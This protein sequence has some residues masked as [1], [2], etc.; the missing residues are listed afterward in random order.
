MQGGDKLFFSPTGQSNH[1]CPLPRSHSPRLA[2]PRIST[3]AW[4]SPGAPLQQVPPRLLQL[5]TRPQPCRCH[6]RIRPSAGSFG[7]RDHGVRRKART[8]GPLPELLA[9]A[10]AHLT[11]ARRDLQLCRAE[12]PGPG[13]RLRRNPPLRT[14]TY[15]ASLGKASRLLLGWV[16]GVRFSLSPSY[17]PDFPITHEGKQHPPG[18]RPAA[19]WPGISRMAYRLPPRCTPSPPFLCTQRAAAV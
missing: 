8:A 14:F 6:P 16:K 7:G 15:G 12:E 18:K 10:P 13:E 4:Q 5:P 19:T 9:A 3:P 17:C 2:Y 11:A 1:G